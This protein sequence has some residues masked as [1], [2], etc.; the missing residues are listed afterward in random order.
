[1]G[2]TIS[3]ELVNHG[4]QRDRLGRVRVPAGRREELLAQF[5]ESGLTR[6]EFARREGVSYTTFC[7]WTQRADKQAGGDSGAQ[8]RAK[9]PARSRPKPIR[10]ADRAPFQT[11]RL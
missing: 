10:F 7:T 5:R 4:E 6:R 11:K 2:T 8:A 9:R 1:M 3:T